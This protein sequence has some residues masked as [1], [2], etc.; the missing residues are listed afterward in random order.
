MDLGFETFFARQSVQSK[1]VFNLFSSNS[2]RLETS[3][4]ICSSID[5][6][7]AE[8]LCLFRQEVKDFSWSDFSLRR[9]A[10]VSGVQFEGFQTKHR[11]TKTFCFG[12]VREMCAFLS[13]SKFHVRILPLQLLKSFLKNIVTELILRIRCLGSISVIPEAST[14][15]V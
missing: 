8:K 14:R 9:V 7:L 11:T 4:S 6:E 12:R 13:F 5:Q 1:Q 15:S 3:S 10:R 2:L